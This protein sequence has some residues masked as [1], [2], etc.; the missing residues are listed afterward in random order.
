[1]IRTGAV[2][3]DLMVNLQPTNAKLLARAQ[4]ILIAAS[5]PI[6]HSTDPLPQT[7][8]EAA[9]SRPP[10]SSPPPSL[11]RRRRGPPRPAPAPLKR[12]LQKSAQPQK[13]PRPLQQS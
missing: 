6:T 13:Y 10:S 3:S 8:A 4:R 9:A 5:L 1:M 12:T 11:P 7:P 2:Y